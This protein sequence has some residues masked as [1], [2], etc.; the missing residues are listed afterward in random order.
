MANF[1]GPYEIEIKYT[2][3]GVTHVNRINCNIA[4]APTIGEDVANI[5]LLTKLG[6][7]INIDVAVKAYVNLVKVLYHSAVSFDSY[8]LYLYSAPNVP[9]TWFAVGS[10]GIV[11][12][13]N[14]AYNPARMITLT[15]RTGEG[16]IMKNVWL[17]DS[18]SFQIRSTHA[19]GDPNWAAVMDYVA[20]N[21][22]WFLAKDTSRPLVPLN[23]VGGQ[24]ERTFRKRYRD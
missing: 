12:T 23:I 6:N 16:G 9:R 15:Y 20:D 8:D 4:I 19:N 2:I 14:S 7:G 24:N 18:G 1:P 5:D 21:D 13:A 3:D 11:G 10:L 22:T 17:E